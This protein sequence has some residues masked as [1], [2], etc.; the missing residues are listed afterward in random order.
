[1]T[2]QTHEEEEILSAVR[3][4]CERVRHIE[5]DLSIITAFCEA[6]LVQTEPQTYVKPAG[7]SFS[8]Q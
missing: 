5:E 3:H 1:M 8:R 7:I 4:L 2:L 6:I